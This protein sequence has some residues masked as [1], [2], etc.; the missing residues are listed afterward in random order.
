MVRERRL[1][2]VCRIGVGTLF[3]ATSLLL[4]DV[5]QDIL[6]LT[7]GVRAKAVWVRSAASQNLA[8]LYNR[9]GSSIL[10]GI[11][12]DEG[13]IRTIDSIRGNHSYPLISRRGEYVVWNQD[14]TN[15]AW[16][17][18][19]P[20]TV[21]WVIKW[22]G[23]GRTKLLDGAAGEN[24]YVLS[25]MLDERTNQEWVYTCRLNNHNTNPN[26]KIFR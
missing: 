10:V 21:S 13:T 2:S 20:N 11:D 12:T 22:D 4:A 8:N 14:P 5:K 6:A 15:N 18:S 17:G 9:G 24:S 23:T 1:V 26:P 16:G 3:V 7:G 25:F 19:S